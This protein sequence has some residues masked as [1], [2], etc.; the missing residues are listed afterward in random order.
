MQSELVKKHKLMQKALIDKIHY[1]NS[2][3]KARVSI[4][5][6][7]EHIKIIKY[8]IIEIENYD[9]CNIFSKKVKFLN[10]E[11]YRLK[12]QLKEDKNGKDHSRT[13]S[14]IKIIEN[15]P[16]TEILKNI[17]ETQA[18]NK[19]L[20]EEIEKSKNALNNEQSYKKNKLVYE[21][22][23]IVIN[24]LR[25]KY[26]KISLEIENALAYSQEDECSKKIRILDT[27]IGQKSE[28]SV[29]VPSPRTTIFAKSNSLL[30]DIEESLSRV[31][32]IA[33]PQP[34]K[35]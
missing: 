18:D 14:A 7:N 20:E 3:E 25:A 12:N 6:T 31:R 9:H 24:E 5:N 30:Q 32:A 11:I 23:K 33:S 2:T 26:Q 28:R 15:I 35:E 1:Q 22:K 27:I 34:K 29:K 10:S 4:E 21:K 8:K 16:E 17:K 13:S 19:A